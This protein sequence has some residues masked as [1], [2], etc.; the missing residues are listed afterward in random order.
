MMDKVGEP[1]RKWEW[2]MPPQT[3]N[4]YANY[5]LLEIVFP[6]AFLQPPFFDPK[7]DAALNYGAIGAIIGHEIS[8]HFDDQGAQFNEA[9]KLANWWTPEDLA[10]FEAAE[11]GADRA[12]RCL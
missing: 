9:G 1:V 12:V 2:L 8:H 7:A 5:S 3:V 11:Q 4:A 10:A 6:A